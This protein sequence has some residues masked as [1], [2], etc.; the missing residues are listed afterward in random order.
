VFASEVI[1]TIAFPS[2]NNNGLSIHDLSVDDAF[3]IF[4]FQKLHLQEVSDKL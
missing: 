3:V 2:C 1:Q 4:L